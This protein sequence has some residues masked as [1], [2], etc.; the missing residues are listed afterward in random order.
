LLFSA[1]APSAAQA[2]ILSWAAWENTAVKIS[3]FSTNLLKRNTRATLNFLKRHPIVVGVVVSAVSFLVWKRLQKNT[4]K[5]GSSNPIIKKI[6]NHGDLKLSAMPRNMQAVQ[7]LLNSGFGI[8]QQDNEGY[9]LLMNAVE[10]GSLDTVKLLLKKGAVVSKQNNN[11]DTALDIVQKRANSL[12]YLSSQHEITKLLELAEKTRNI[13]ERILYDETYI[14]Q[15]CDF[16]S[17]KD[18]EEVK[19]IFK[20]NWSLLGW[21]KPPSPKDVAD[22]ITGLANTQKNSR[23]FFKI[24][25]EQDKVA[26]F[27]VYEKIPGGY[28]RFLAID[29]QYRRKGHGERLLRYALQDLTSK[30]TVKVRLET[31]NNNHPAQ[32]LYRKIGFKKVKET[33]KEVFFNLNIEEEFPHQVLHQMLQSENC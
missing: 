28:L 2:G 16:D 30:G 1:I 20:L 12:C 23:I 27:V 26:G 6:K 32:K 21:D 31:N 4:K 5:S 7:S 18:T 24:L 17:T 11:G 25:R 8:D 19:K 22:R 9:T 10:F 14:K 13:R 3:S 33:D 15:I 29:Q